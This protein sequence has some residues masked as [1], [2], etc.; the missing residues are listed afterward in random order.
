MTYTHHI[1]GRIRARLAAIKRNPAQAAAL[2][3]WLASLDGVK[4]VETNPLTGSVLIQ[5]AEAEVRGEDLMARMRERRWIANSPETPALPR[6][7]GVRRRP[8]ADSLQGKLAKTILQIA[9][10]VAIE[11]SVLALAAAIL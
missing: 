6:A 11:R 9:A 2:Q 5:Y 3:Q 1:P 4:R 10:Q 7:A 8:A